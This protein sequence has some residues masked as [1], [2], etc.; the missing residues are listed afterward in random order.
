MRITRLKRWQIKYKK[1]S[2]TPFSQRISALVRYIFVDIV[3]DIFAILTPKNPRLVLSPDKH[4]LFIEPLKQGYGD[5][6]FQ[7]PVFEFIGQNAQLDILVQPNH[8]VI[9]DNNP[10]ICNVFSKID[11]VNTQKY[12]YVIYLIHSTINENLYAFKCS[13]AKKVPLDIDLDV[14][15]NI[16]S[17]NSHTT[18]WQKLIDHFQDRTSN[19]SLPRLYIANKHIET[20]CDIVII[21]G[22]ERKEKSIKNLSG[23]ISTIS[24]N[25]P[26][27]NIAIV[28]R[29]EHLTEVPNLSNVRNLINKTTY[30]ECIDIIA[31]AKIVIGPEGSLIHISTTLKTPTIVGEYGRSF[32]KYSNIT[33]NHIIKFNELDDLNTI[34]AIKLLL[35]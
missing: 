5:L 35:N 29:T 7:T 34:S 20:T 23:I 3:N 18:A 4:I 10:N 6:L 25:F 28:G 33:G 13:N 2:D 12:D 15:A 19:Y 22:A 1:L 32:S 27:Q 11:A 31:N 24:K 21:G 9:I 30:A 16:F 14:W 8:R 26:T 17:N